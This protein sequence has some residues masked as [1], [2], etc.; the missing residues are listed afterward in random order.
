M[1]DSLT[2]F[3][4]PFVRNVCSPSKKVC[5]LSIGNIGHM[6]V[7]FAK[8]LGVEVYA[9]SSFFFKEGRCFEVRSRPFH[10]YKERANFV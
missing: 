2:V 9:L 5:I 7:L 4:L 6:F 3:P 1:C 8:A 10:C